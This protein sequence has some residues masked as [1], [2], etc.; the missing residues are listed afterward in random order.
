MPLGLACGRW[1]VRGNYRAEFVGTRRPGHP[2]DRLK[3]L[4]S[5]ERQRHNRQAEP[6]EGQPFRGACDPLGVVCSFQRK[7][8]S[9][10]GSVGGAE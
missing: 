8:P 3:I 10:E 1:V 2:A 9:Q 4:A 7:S 5:S 6:N